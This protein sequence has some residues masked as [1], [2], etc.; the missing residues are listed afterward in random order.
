MKGTNRPARTAHR[1]REARPFRIAP[2][3]E[4]HAEA[5]ARVVR[6]AH[7]VADDE[8]CPSC[9]EAAAVRRQIRRF[10]AGQF[11][12]VEGRGEGER[13]IGAAMLMRT[14][15]PPNARPKAWLDMIGGLGLRHHDPSGRWLYGVEIAVDP[16]AQGHG[17]GSA[18][19]S[20]RLALVR[21][22]DLDG[23]YAGG[24][25]KGYRRYRGRLTPREYA[26]RVRRG[27]IEDPTVSMQINRGFRAAGIIE[28]YDEDDESGNCAMLI[29]WKA[30]TARRR[31]V[32]PRSAREA[33][34]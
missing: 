34:V 22:L 5:V 6:R 10:P 28:D 33:Q 16:D 14:G 15:Y 8:I 12:A 24:M 31:P 4:R 13:V 3:A 9:P 17:V 7:S 29:V 30:G 21:E 23:M 27:E 32:A 18:L 25:L 26:E 11:I 1:R 2:T 19:Y 20:R